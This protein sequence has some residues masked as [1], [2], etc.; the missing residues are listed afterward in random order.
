MAVS[1]H[2]HAQNMLNYFPADLDWVIFFFLFETGSLFVVR[3]YFF[4]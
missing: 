3:D 2:R 1:D 4:P